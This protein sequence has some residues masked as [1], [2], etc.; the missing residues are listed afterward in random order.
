MVFEIFLGLEHDEALFE[1]VLLSAGEVGLLKMLLQI[2]V[3]PIK[4]VLIFLVT[5]VALD[6]FDFQMGAKEVVIEETGI[7]ELFTYRL[8]VQ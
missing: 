8:T 4:H 1:A 7:A 3:F 6:V 2:L 5:E